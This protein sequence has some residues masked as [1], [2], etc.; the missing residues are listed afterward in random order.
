MEV[1]GSSKHNLE[2]HSMGKTSKRNKAMEDIL[3]NKRRDGLK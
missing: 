1:P 3:R 2:A